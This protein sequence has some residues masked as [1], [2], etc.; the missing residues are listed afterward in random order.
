MEGSAH[1]CS[2]C[3]VGCWRSPT[4]HGFCRTASLPSVPGPHSWWCPKA[5]D[6]SPQLGHP[7]LLT[8]RY[9]RSP[10]SRGCWAPSCTAGAC[11]PGGAKE[12][13]KHTGGSLHAEP[14]LA[15]QPPS[16]GRRSPGRGCPCAGGRCPQRRRH[17]ISASRSCRGIQNA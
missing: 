3:R 1:S 8:H 12:G 13:G 9:Q 11:R 10:R 17:A 2:V 14:P 16:M 6:L 7:P 4:C 5:G 15:H